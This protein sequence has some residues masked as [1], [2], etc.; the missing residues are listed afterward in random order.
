MAKKNKKNILGVEKVGNYERSAMKEI[1]SYTIFGVLLFFVGILFGAISSGVQ[2]Y[3]SD[4]DNPTDLNTQKFVTS[5]DSVVSTDE[6]DVNSI[7]DVDND[8]E[9]VEEDF[10][11]I[12]PE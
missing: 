8:I 12:F 7:S 11:E 3:N 6:I 9:E 2:M 1:E 4:K 5:P 10:Q